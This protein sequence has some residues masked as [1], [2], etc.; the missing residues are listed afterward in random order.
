MDR[1]DSRFSDLI[2][3]GIAVALIGAII[4]LFEKTHLISDLSRSAAVAIAN[5]AGIPSRDLTTEIV[6]GGLQLPWTQDC[7]GINALIMLAA[8]TVWVNR[9]NLW[10]ISALL[11]LVACLP[12]A[13]TVNTC[14]V[15]TIAMYR[16]VF[17]PDWETPELHY[18]IGFLWLLPCLPLL[19]PRFRQQDRQFWLNTF[20]S[21]V[22]LSLAAPL[23]LN[24]N[25]MLVVFCTLWFMFWNSFQPL[26][27]TQLWLFVPW[28]F[29]AVLVAASASESL[30]IPLLLA[31]PGFA[32]GRALRSPFALGLLAGTIPVIAM[33][34][35]GTG[36]I[37]LCFV[38]EFYRLLYRPA[39]KDDM[40]AESSLLPTPIALAILSSPLLLPV[41]TALEHEVV[42]P[43]PT[44]MARKI[45]SNIFQVRSIG[46]PQQLSA[47]WFGPFGDGRHH[48][49]TA[50]LTFRGVEVTPVKG[51]E[52]TYRGEGKWMTEYF[53]QGDE[54]ITSY[55]QYLLSTILP[56]SSPGAHIIIEA[57]LNKMR[58]EQF[59]READRV[60]QKLTSRPG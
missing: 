11:R 53:V 26:R 49:L 4:V 45:E 1:P 56:T 25:G 37:A 24:Q 48:S 35:L 9:E 43:P 17:Y 60:A 51:V 59:R 23:V 55:E 50:C 27:Q 42:N 12:L 39:V 19:V 33:N 40:R 7:S 10:S 32:N 52:N 20:Y 8:V 31:A 6:L 5:L 28:S 46:Q 57:D 30:W 14:R 41:L 21:V 16:Y 58:A 38:V 36:V 44:V 29:L 22:L 13:L 15:M 54:L 18:F 3:S 34:P 2:P 47:F